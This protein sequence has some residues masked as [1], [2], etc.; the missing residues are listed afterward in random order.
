MAY[1]EPFL[2]FSDM[3][4]FV[5]YDRELNADVNLRLA[6]YVLP[7]KNSNLAKRIRSDTRKIIFL[8][9]AY[10]LTDIVKDKSFVNFYE[11]GKYKGI[12][13]VQDFML[14]KM[15]MPDDFK[16]GVFHLCNQ[17]C[18]IVGKDG[19]TVDLLVF[20][21]C[22]VSSDIFA[23]V[24]DEDLHAFIKVIKQYLLYVEYNYQPGIINECCTREV[25]LFSSFI[26]TRLYKNSSSLKEHKYDAFAQANSSH[27]ALKEAVRIH[28]IEYGRN[29]SSITKKSEGKVE[30]T[31]KNYLILHADK[32]NCITIK[33]SPCQMAIYCYIQ[34]FKN[35]G[36]SRKNL[37]A[38]ANGNRGKYRK[39]CA[40]FG[41]S[42]S[43]YTI[44]KLKV[45][46]TQI[47]SRI[48][49]T[50]SSGNSAETGLRSF[51]FEPWTE[52][53]LIKSDG[54]KYSIGVSDLKFKPVI[55][56][57]NRRF[58]GNP[59]AFIDKL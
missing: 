49:A 36:I 34:N 7:D 20:S 16:S 22:E 25:N 33:L 55:I 42:H 46:V 51:N 54:D 12:G 56:D 44:S 38:D 29:F 32:K 13:K 59:D 2:Q 52:S 5:F 8:P 23:E 40:L 43:D 21:G 18:S 35:K 6:R 45:V 39:L 15:G 57:D 48:K 11:S 26:K 47:N 19:K 41:A 28:M 10:R 17:K 24:S 3:R 4:H 1:R 9:E 30:Y 50:L 53:M 27:G 37:L 58:V 14:R 31:K